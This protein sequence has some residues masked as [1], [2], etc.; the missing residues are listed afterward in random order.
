MNKLSMTTLLNTC[1]EIFPNEASIA[2][3]NSQSSYIIDQ[4]KQWIYK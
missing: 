1:S 2:V 4:A 3:A